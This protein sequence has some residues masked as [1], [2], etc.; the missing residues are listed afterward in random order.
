MLP[1]VAGPVGVGGVTSSSEPAGIAASDPSGGSLLHPVQQL[2]LKL[3][4]RKM[5]TETLVIDHVEKEPT[6]N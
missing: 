3:D 4:P 6:V 5:P 2:G 1:E